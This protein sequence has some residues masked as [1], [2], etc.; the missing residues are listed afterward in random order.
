MN[1]I[2]KYEGLRGDDEPQKSGNS[3]NWNNAIDSALNTLLAFFGKGQNSQT[4]TPEK[5]NVNVTVQ[6]DKTLTY[7]GLGCLALMGIFVLTNSGKK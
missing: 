7:I 6:Q 3:V 2:F 4:T 1:E 5:Q